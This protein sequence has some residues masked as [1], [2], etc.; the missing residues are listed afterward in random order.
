MSPRLFV[1]PDAISAPSV[2]KYVEVNGSGAGS[3]VSRRRS[4]SSLTEYGSTC[5]T[6]GRTSTDAPGPPSAQSSPQ[7]PA[8]AAARARRRSV[9]GRRGR[10][11][12]SRPGA[13]GSPARRC[14]GR[15]PRSKRCRPLARYAVTAPC[16]TPR[17][18][19][20]SSRCATCCARPV[21]A[22]RARGCGPRRP[23]RRDSTSAWNRRPLRSTRTMSPMPM[24]FDVRR[25][26]RLRRSGG[27]DVEEGRL[28]AHADHDTASRGRTAR[29]PARSRPRAGAARGSRRGR[30]AR[31]RASGRR[32]SA[33]RP[34]TRPGHSA[35]AERRGDLLGVETGRRG[36]VL[37]EGVVLR[38]D[39]Q[40]VEDPAAAVVEQ[41]DRERQTRVPA[42]GEQAADVVGERHVAASAGPSV[43]ASPRRTR[44]RPCR[45]FR[46]RRGWPARAAGRRA[47]RRRSRRRGSGIEAATNSVDVRAAGSRRG[48]ARRRARSDALVAQRGLL[49]ASRGE[50][51][52]PPGGEPAPARP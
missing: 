39:R 32:A 35:E 15:R 3:T 26:L 28:S 16:A 27:F 22:R 9:R 48:A 7:A 4:G 52:P 51:G 6:P 10:G 37:L 50:V 11:P 14:G 17:R 41:H 1:L 30:C 21:A 5:T 36:D 31:G 13:A 8:R 43:P 25:T 42:R 46:W 12:A 18:P 33:R 38:A 45:R 24:P 40:E 19:R 44:S 34:A 20:G 2:W 47:G 29:R 23:A 49:R